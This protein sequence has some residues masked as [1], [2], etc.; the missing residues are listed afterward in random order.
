MDRVYGSMAGISDAT[1]PS[2]SLLPT[3]SG[4]PS[5]T[6][7]I[8]WGS[9]AERAVKANRPFKSFSVSI[10]AS[11]RLPLK[12]FSMQVRDDFGVRFR[13]ECDALRR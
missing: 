2:S 3:M 5:R 12:C 9:S 4:A 7:T 10:T 8:F 6:A 1:K 11:S 13:G